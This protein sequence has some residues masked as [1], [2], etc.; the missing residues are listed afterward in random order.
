MGVV[1]VERVE[2]TIASASIVPVDIVL[3]GGQTPSNC[4]PFITQNNDGDDEYS[5]FLIRAYPGAG[6]VMTVVRE[7]AGSDTTVYLSVLEFDDGEVQSGSLYTEFSTTTVTVSITAVVLANAFLVFNYSST[8]G[9]DDR[10][11]FY[12]RGY[13]SAADEITFEVSTAWTPNGA[14]ITLQWFVVESSSLSV[15][16]IQGAFTGGSGTQDES[17]SAVD[18]AKTLV[19]GSHTAGDDNSRLRQVSLYL[20]DATTL[21]ARRNGGGVPGTPN[22]TFAA[23]IVES[24]DF[25]V[26]QGLI[27]STNTTTGTVALSTL[28]D[29]SRSAAF[30][31]TPMGSGDTEANSGFHRSFG[32]ELTDASTL[33]WGR[34]SHADTWYMPWQVVT[35]P[36]TDDSMSGTAAGST[37]MSG[38]LVDGAQAFL[39]SGALGADAPA[40]SGSLGADV[41]PWSGSLSEG[42]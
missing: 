37:T 7:E 32:L 35:F 18:L 21:R 34:D 3:A 15:Q 4:V 22:N 24:D 29:L 27:T 33:T 30:G 12:V 28:S 38:V 36:Q 9:F 23:Q 5:R 41:G 13:L 42:G 6:P 14:Q 31:T 16:H 25:T 26:Q 40:L 17:I 8:R 10:G 11:E 19:F 39:W 20:P 1:S 2:T